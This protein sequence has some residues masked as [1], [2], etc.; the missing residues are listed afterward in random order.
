MANFAKNMFVIAITVATVATF[1]LGFVAPQVAQAAGVGSLVKGPNSDAVY[2]IGD[3]STKYIFP[4]AKTYFS[5]YSDFSGVELL[6][7]AELDTY[8]DGGSVLYRAGTKLIT[9]PNTNKVYVVEP[10]GAIRWITSEE[11]AA[12]LYGA[13][14]QVGLMIFQKF[15]S[16][17]IQQGQI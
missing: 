17:S 7:V 10:S 15:S 14:G 2:Y 16:L 9:H 11:V 8:A 12:G 4:D 6:T 1:G 13:A 3:N 5:W